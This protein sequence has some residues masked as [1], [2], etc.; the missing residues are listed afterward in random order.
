[1][2]GG[3]A[4]SDLGCPGQSPVIWLAQPLFTA[5]EAGLRARRR[6]PVAQQSWRRRRRC[7]II[8]SVRSRVHAVVL[9]SEIGEFADEARR[10]FQD[11]QASPAASPSIGECSPAVDV[12]ETEETI[13][14]TMDLPG[15]DPQSIR[16]IVKGAGVLLV[17]EKAARRRWSGASFHLVERGFGRFARL[18]RLTAPC[19]TGK[20]T[21][22]LERGEL[23]VTLPKRLE[24]RG[25]A[26]HVPITSVR[27]S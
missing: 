21:A 1:M 24:R 11:I 13:E 2:C 3:H 19:D 8:R 17:G 12:Y 22:A 26:I 25:R 4:K 5:L 9:T 16:V 18:V 27:P 23:R 20:A 7:A 10:A 14:I 15:V 6:L